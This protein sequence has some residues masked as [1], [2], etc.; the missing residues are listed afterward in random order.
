MLQW[1]SVDRCDERGSRVLMASDRVSTILLQF[2]SKVDIASTGANTTIIFIF[3]TLFL[4]SSMLFYRLSTKQ[5]VNHTRQ[6][7]AVGDGRLRPRCRHVRSGQNIRVGL[8]LACSVLRPQVTSG[9][10]V[11]TLFRRRELRRQL[12]T[13]NCNWKAK[14]CPE[15]S[16]N[17]KNISLIQI[18]QAS[19][20]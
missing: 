18:Q 10:K 11:I 17:K 1:Q 6:K 12:Y 16:Q 19:P 2:L 13:L 14:S 20:L 5:W 15:L 7:D 4:L 8:T 3:I 9:S